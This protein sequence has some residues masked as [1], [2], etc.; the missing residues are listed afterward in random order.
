MM[1]WGFDLHGVLNEKPKGNPGFFSELTTL[2]VDGGHEV[3]VIT[4][5]RDSQELRDELH[6]LGIKYTHLFS[7]TSHLE[8]QTDH[9][10][11]YDDHGNPYVGDE[12]WDTIKGKYCSDNG[13][14]FHIDDT[15]S[16]L[17]HFTT[18][19]AR[20]YSKDKPYTK[21]VKAYGAPPVKF[22]VN[23]ATSGEPVVITMEKTLTPDDIVTGPKV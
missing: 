14:H 10:I 4:G 3:H 13:V 6:E 12:I 5:G 1:I 16:Y 8:H 11:T 21:R 20:F 7:L 2:L 15:D 9:H 19:V 22:T 18:P 23:D 17:N